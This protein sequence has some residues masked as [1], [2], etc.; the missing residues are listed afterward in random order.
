MSGSRA[1]RPVPA[2]QRSGTTGPRG[3]SG[4][5]FVAPMLVFTTLIRAR[6]RGAFAYGELAE[7]LG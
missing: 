7:A 5:L 1:P 2:W 6:K 4:G 3:A